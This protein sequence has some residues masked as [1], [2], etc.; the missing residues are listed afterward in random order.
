MQ[1]AGGLGKRGRMKLTLDTAPLVFLGIGLLFLTVAGTAYLLGA[2]S[3]MAVIGIGA[4][5][6]LVAMATAIVPSK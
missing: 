4:M 2:G 5:F 1:H 3:S 6:V